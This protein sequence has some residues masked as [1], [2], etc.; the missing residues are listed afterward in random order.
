LDVRPD[1]LVR[2]GEVGNNGS[3]ESLI[4]GVAELDRAPAVFIGLEGM[5]AVVDNWV[6][7]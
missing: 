5:D 3:G 4:S 2:L 1:V 7:E 6:V